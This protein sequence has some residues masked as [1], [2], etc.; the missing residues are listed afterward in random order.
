MACRM[1]VFP[2]P[3]DPADV[4]FLDVNTIRYIAAVAAGD[5]ACDLTILTTVTLG[6]D[7]T[8]VATSGHI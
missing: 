2:L 5:Y 7:G 3:L 1:C 8:Y 4:P 6:T